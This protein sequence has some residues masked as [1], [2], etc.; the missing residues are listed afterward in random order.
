MG[1]RPDD[2][3][4]CYSW[5]EGSVPPPYHYEYTISV[6]P[7]GDGIIVFRPDY[8][9]EGAPAW[10]ER[11]RVSH[12]RLAELCRRMFEGGVFSTQWET[13]PEPGPVGGELEWLEVTARGERYLVPQLPLH[14][15][16]LRP[17]YDFIRTLVP[18][19]IWSK[20]R[21]QQE[22]YQAAHRDR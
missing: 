19:A 2:F 13:H 15:E 12:A 3:S 18:E 17:L 20:L 1:Q 11:F 16:P 21:A 14:P 4:F 6:W 10:E 8:P 7:I 22:A 5:R 9:E